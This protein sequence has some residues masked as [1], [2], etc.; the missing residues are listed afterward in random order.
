[1]K[2]MYLV[3]ALPLLFGGCMMLGAGG[4]GLTGGG[5]MHGSS[6][7]NALSGQLLIKESVVDGI[8]V[9]AQFPPHA[10]GENPTYTVTLVDVRQ[11]APLSD[12]SVSLLVSPR[13]QG[14]DA[15][16]S[17]PSSAHAAHGE[18]SA[19]PSEGNQGAMTLSPA[20]HRNGTFLFRPAITTAG[21]YSFVYRIARPGDAS[22]DPP[23]EVEQTVYL[24]VPATRVSGNGEHGM[25]GGMGSGMGP[26]VLIGAGVMAIMMLFMFR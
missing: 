21:T 23:V 3:L 1:M 12:A 25:G 16:R 22:I 6:H 18:T 24:G 26:T 15:S 8:R 4:M 11:D 10:V 13:E 17:A 19:T 14:N 7:G 5:G 9:T 20:E 2:K